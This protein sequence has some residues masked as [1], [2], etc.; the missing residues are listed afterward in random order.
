MHRATKDLDLLGYGDP[1]TEMVVHRFQEIITTPVEDDGLVFQQLRTEPIRPDEEYGGI[2][3]VMRAFG[4][5]GKLGPGW[6]VALGHSL[7]QKGGIPERQHA[8][9]PT[10]RKLLDY[11]Q[12][13]FLLGLTA[14]PERSD[15]GDLLALCRRNLMFRCDRGA[16]FDLGP[17]DEALARCF[18]LLR[19]GGSPQLPR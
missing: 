17:G 15:G 19:S 18:E 12:P 6:L 14:T 3:F 2:R 16:L 13:R 8:D 9:A 11:F 1:G 4:R 5:I 7:T 10:Y